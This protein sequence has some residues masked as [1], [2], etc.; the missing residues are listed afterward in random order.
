MVAVLASKS[1]EFISI[2]IYWEVEIE[3]WGTGMAVAPHTLIH[4]QYVSMIL[5]YLKEFCVTVCSFVTYASI[6]NKAII[7]VGE[8]GLPLSTGV[9]GHNR[10]IVLAEGPGPSALDHDFHVHGIVPSVTFVYS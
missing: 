4:M 5:R 1:L 6:D 10:S 3:I 8:P 7:P 9:R 2:E